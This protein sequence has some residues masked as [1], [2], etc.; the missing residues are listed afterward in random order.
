MT[1]L[2][3]LQFVHIKMVYDLIQQ[4]FYAASI[5]SQFKKSS[6]S[7]EIKTIPNSMPMSTSGTTRCATLDSVEGDQAMIIDLPLIENKILPNQSRQVVSAGALVQTK[8]SDSVFKF[9]RPQTA[10]THDPSNK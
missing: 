8:L 6:D 3:G 1:Q 5:P 9:T 7:L 10:K 4:K 2:T